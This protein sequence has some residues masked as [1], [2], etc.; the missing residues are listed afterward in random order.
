M[1]QRDFKVSMAD[2]GLSMVGIL[3]IAQI[4]FD[5]APVARKAPPEPEKKSFWKR[6]FG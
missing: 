2:G 6:L 5:N 3:Q 1:G 4:A